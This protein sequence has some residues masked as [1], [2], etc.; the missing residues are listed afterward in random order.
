MSEV[1]ESV[2][3]DPID[4]S[5]DSSDCD[6]NL[7]CFNLGKKNRIYH[8]EGVCKYCGV[9]IIKWDRLHHQNISDIDF[10]IDS[11]EKEYI[12]HYYWH[13][14][15]PIT[16]KNYALRKGIAEL[17]VSIK[18]RI[19]QALIP[20]QPIRDGYQTPFHSKNPIHYAQHA[21]ATCCRKCLH[22]WHGIELGRELL[23]N[24]IA[25]TTALIMEFITRKVPGLTQFKQTIPNIRK[26]Y[27]NN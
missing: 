10:T 5:C 1:N 24:E 22:Y 14:D 17:E 3:L 20:S 4:I 2:L 11:L 6:N 12:R 25:Y 26:R 13:I 21:T 23:P 15:L 27:A 8:E 7:H 18:K 19:K 16:A 9:N